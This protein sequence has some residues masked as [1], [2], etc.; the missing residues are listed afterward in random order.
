MVFGQA[1][2]QYLL[3]PYQKEAYMVVILKR[4]LI[5]AP[6]AQLSV[7]LQSTV[8]FLLYWEIQIILVS[9]R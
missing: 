6:Q 3:N 7:H 5:Q 4:Y 9:T 8:W 2:S 1:P